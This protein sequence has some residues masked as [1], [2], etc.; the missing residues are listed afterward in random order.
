MKASTSPAVSIYSDRPWHWNNQLT[1][2]HPSIQYLHIHHVPGPVLE[3]SSIS[4]YWEIQQQQATFMELKSINE[5]LQN[6]LKRSLQI[7]VNVRMETGCCD[8]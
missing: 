8:K 5:E 2:I 1:V 6:K 3:P 4:K 7:A